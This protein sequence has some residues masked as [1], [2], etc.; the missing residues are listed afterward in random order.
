MKTELVQVGADATVCVRSLSQKHTLK[1]KYFIVYTKA[2]HILLN[3]LQRFYA[4]M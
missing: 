1:Y 3:P 4:E 2:G